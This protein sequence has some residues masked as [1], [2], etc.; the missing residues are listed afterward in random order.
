MKTK[1]PIIALL[2]LI[3]LCFA[4]FDASALGGHGGHGFMG[5]HLKGVLAK[6]GVPLTDEQKT[7]IKEIFQQNRDQMKAT[8]T[9]L[10]QARQALS[11]SMLSEQQADDAIKVQVDKTIVP[12]IQTMAENRAASYNQILWTVL[13][14]DQR[15]ALQAF[16][17]PKQTQP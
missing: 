3:V 5:K 16:G 4:A 6:A 1:M 10:F 17:G 12:L 15:A 7:L 14:A 11:A 2:S 13:T 9:A 8:R